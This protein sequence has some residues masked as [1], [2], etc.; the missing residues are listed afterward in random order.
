V[1]K[2]RTTKPADAL[3]K[4]GGSPKGFTLRPYQ[5]ELNEQTGVA[6]KAKKLPLV[7]LPD[8]EQRTAERDRVFFDFWGGR[9]A[10]LKEAMGRRAK[11]GVGALE[12][13]KYCIIKIR[14]RFFI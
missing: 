12:I 3:A 4:P 2:H 8:G 7:V 9:L 11:L 5:K 14:W 13:E 10:V 6:L 1:A